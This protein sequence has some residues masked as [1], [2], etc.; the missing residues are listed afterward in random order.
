MGF[1]AVQA[2]PQEIP[3]WQEATGISVDA[4]SVV[5]TWDQGR[6]LTSLLET[7]QEAGQ[8]AIVIS[9]EPW[10]LVPPTLPTAVRAR[11]QPRWGVENIVSGS[12][13]TYIR[14]V[15][16]SIKDSGM[17]DV[18]LRIAPYF[19]GELRPWGAHAPLFIHAWHRIVDI[20]FETGADHVRPVWAPTMRIDQTPAEWSRSV[21]EYWPSA[22]YV[23][24]I[25][26][27]IANPDGAST[28]GVVRQ[29]GRVG[30]LEQ[31]TGCPVI[32]T[33]FQTAWGSRR[34]TLDYISSWVDE[35]PYLRGF[36]LDQPALS[37]GEG[38]GYSDDDLTWNLTGDR[39]VCDAVKEMAAVLRA[40]GI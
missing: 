24:Y 4:A 40:K 25:G 11:P 19:N 16:R 18:Y 36:V 20:L 13:D 8:Q 15:A 22:G 29:L 10:V 32:V 28:E 7:A 33:G 17:P 12:H 14:D 39:E 31:L 2:A 23:D 38:T 21:L 26:L 35:A 34:D 3:T 30:L 27:D 5:E 9:W 37:L 6:E 1:F